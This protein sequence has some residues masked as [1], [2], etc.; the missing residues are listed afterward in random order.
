MIAALH[1]WGDAFMRTF[2]YYTPAD[3]HL[4]EEI[5]RDT[6]KAVGAIDLTVSRSAR[7]DRECVRLLTFMYSGAMHLC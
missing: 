7:G 5:D 2:K 6:G 4:S 1:G 3:G